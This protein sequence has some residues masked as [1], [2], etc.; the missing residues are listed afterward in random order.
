MRRLPAIV[1]LALIAAAIGSGVYAVLPGF[2]SG[3]W[4]GSR[5]LS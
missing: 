3:D 2:E 4:L 1:T 5:A